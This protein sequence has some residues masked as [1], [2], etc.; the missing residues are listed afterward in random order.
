MLSWYA[1]FAALF[2][3]QSSCLSLAGGKEAKEGVCIPCQAP[4]PCCTKGQYCPGSIACCDCGANDCSCPSPSAPS[5]TSPP[6]PVISPTHKAPTPASPT[7][8]PKPTP[9]PVPTAPT[10]FEPNPPVWPASVSVF[11]PSDTNIQSIIDAA[12]RTNGGHEPPDH[13]QF[14]DERYA[15]L[16]KPGV[17]SVDV[18]VGYYTSV[19]GLGEKASDVEFT[20]LK[21]VH[22]TQ[23][24]YNFAIGAL[25]SFWR[26]AEN[27]KTHANYQWFAGEGHGMLW[28]VSQATFL[29]RI[30]VVHSLVL[31]QYTY[32]DAAGFA[33][34]GYLSNSEVSTIYSGSQQQWFTRNSKVGAWYGGVWNMVFVGTNGAPGSH[35]GRGPQGLQNAYVTVDQ[36]PIV[37]EKPFITID[38]NGKY[39]LQVPNPK[40]NSAGPQLTLAD[41]M[42]YDFKDVFVARASDSTSTIVAKLAAGRHVVLSPGI[43]HLS[44]TLVLTSNNQVL[45]GLGY[46]TL[47]PPSNGEPCV[48]VLP[49]LE[50]V[51]I[52]GILL[53]AGSAATKTL[54]QWGDSGAQ[55][56][57]NPSNPGFLHDIFAR[58]G[59]P[60]RTP[61]QADVMLAIYSGNVVGDNF[62]LWR[63]DHSVDGLVVNSA[64]PCKN[65]LVVEG[66]DVTMYGLAVEHTLEDNV[67]WNGER[68]RT[69]FFQCE[70]PYDV[71]QANFGDKGFAAYRVAPQVTRHEAYGAGAYHYFR[72][73]AVKVKSAIVCPSSLE[74]N[75]HSPLSVYL[76]GMGTVSYLVNQR[77]METSP[78]SPVS[79]PGAHPAWICPTKM[80]NATK[81]LSSR[82]SQKAKIRAKKL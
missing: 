22:S 4:G 76:N 52:A 55:D 24:D 67:I 13:G 8:V 51:R 42:T 37:A 26:G 74:D 14:S 3:Q 59:G 77:G 46:A 70:F 17:Y 30:E 39:Y 80:L 29:R 10:A 69:Y 61:V 65:A 31:Y 50:G 75:F 43:Y 62:W 53:Q 35:C 66:D 44:E 23:G 73:E 45:L 82:K 54:L 12:Y 33:S 79:T 25:N 57:G 56:S 58:I 78:S 2:L 68:G 1:A 64:N 81:V 6:S 5:P 21:A 16:F 60:D 38:S 32:G 72:D 20:S 11:S 34:G 15:F 40:E 27:F 19:H 28:A 49:N 48:R 36:T 18:P 41:T 71:T 7:P 9:V 47:I 63:A